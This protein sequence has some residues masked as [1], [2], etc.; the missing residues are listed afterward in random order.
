MTQVTIHQCAAH[1][2]WPLRNSMLAIAPNT[3]YPPYPQDDLASSIHLK[4]CLEYHDIGCL[5]LVEDIHE[6]FNKA[7]QIRLRGMAVLTHAQRKGIGAKLINYAVEI[8]RERN[9]TFLWCHARSAAVPFYKAQGFHT[10]G[11][12][13]MIDGI[14]PHYLMFQQL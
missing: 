11:E 3:T 8:L 14:G 5:S 10:N 1:E 7:Q 4:A 6:N 12:E 9:Q 2:I 13:Y